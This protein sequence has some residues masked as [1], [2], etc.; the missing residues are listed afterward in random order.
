MQDQQ[1][2][3]NNNNKYIE[4]RLSKVTLS[5]IGFVFFATKLHSFLEAS[6]NN[7]NNNKRGIHQKI[8]QRSMYHGGVNKNPSKNDAEC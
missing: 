7:E 3:N 5:T 8:I 4:F 1:I 2:N 6:K